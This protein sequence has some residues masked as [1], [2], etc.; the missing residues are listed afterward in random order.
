MRGPEMAFQAFRDGIGHPRRASATSPDGE[1][2]RLR[3]LNDAALICVLA[4]PQLIWLA[5]VLYLL[6]R[7]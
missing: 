7:T 4:F 5:L 2:S 6:H 3:R 1:S